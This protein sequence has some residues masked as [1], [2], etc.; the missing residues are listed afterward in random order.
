MP[1]LSTKKLPE[2]T[3][4]CDAMLGFVNI[5]LGVAFSFLLDGWLFGGMI[6]LEGMSINPETAGLVVQTLAAFVG[7]LAFA[8]LFGVPRAQYITAGITGAVGWCL[9]LVLVR[10][11]GVSP[12]VAIILSSVLIC[13][14]ARVAAIAQKCPAQV[15]LLCGI[16]P[17]VPGAGIFWCTYY[18][19]SGQLAESL[20]T[21]FGAVKAAVAIVLGIIVAMELPQRIFSGKRPKPEQDIH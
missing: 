14:L 13:I 19:V 8:D 2:S 9:Y 4:K 18:L 6:V 5:A 20:T 17:L 16:F 1:L 21:G 3:P 7:T 15:F 12:V 11:A 10:L